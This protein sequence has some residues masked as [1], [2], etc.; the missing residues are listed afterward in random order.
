MQS[1]FNTQLCETAYRQEHPSIRKTQLLRI[2]G[3]INYL[4][5]RKVSL[6]AKI[7]STQPS[8]PIRLL[9]KVR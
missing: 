3:C 9:S 6:N 8:V 2:D 1:V 4:F 5:R 7:I